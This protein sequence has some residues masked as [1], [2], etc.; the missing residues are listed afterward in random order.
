MSNTRDP[1]TLASLHPS[2]PREVHYRSFRSSVRLHGSH[3]MTLRRMSRMP[4]SARDYRP[5]DP[6][7]LIDW[8]AYARS[9]QL[10][11]REI[12]DEASARVAIALDAGE[13]MRWPPEG[14][15]LPRDRGAPPP[16]KAEVAL[17]VAMNVAHL[18]LRMGDI[19]ELWL[20][21]DDKKAKLSSLLR[22]R[23]PVDLVAAFERIAAA[24]FTHEALSSEFRPAEPDDRR[25][26]LA[27]WV[28][29]GLGPGDHQTFLNSGKRQ[30]FLHVLSS[31]E[32]DVNW[33]EGDTSYFDEGRERREYQGQVLTH[34]SNYV[35]SLA[36]WR[37][38]LRTTL[39]ARGGEYLLLS[40]RTGI[41]EFQAGIQSF[42]RA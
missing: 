31:L 10:I 4:E 7:N 39:Q 18:H 40:D 11:V 5:G 25:R 29:D 2:Q 13:T 20:V 16:A 30:L 21:G 26:D 22:P 42:T 35:N 17:R 33:V 41:A 15:E 12:R 1:S 23:S 38:K 27:V 19:V 3:F 28:G 37:E 9:D 36:R 8:K 34:R 14:L 24:G 32:L 6:I